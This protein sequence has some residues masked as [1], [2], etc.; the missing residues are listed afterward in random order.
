MKIDG[1]ERYRLGNL[2]YMEP[3]NTGRLMEYFDGIR[4]S[5][6]SQDKVPFLKLLALNLRLIGPYMPLYA[7]AYFTNNLTVSRFEK[8]SSGAFRTECRII[9]S[10]DARIG[11]DIDSKEDVERLRSIGHDVSYK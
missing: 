9:E 1:V 7:L 10:N 11:I 8:V 4:A 2:A 6:K 5:R 3:E